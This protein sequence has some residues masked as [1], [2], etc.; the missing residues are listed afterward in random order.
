MGKREGEGVEFNSSGFKLYKGYFKNDLYENNGVLYY[1]CG[2]VEYEG[3][4][5]S[6]KKNGLGKLFYSD[7]ELRY[8]GNFYKDSQISDF[9]YFDIKLRLFV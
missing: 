4:F 8:S 9:S 2:A 5:K 6:G 3:K 1:P 7:G